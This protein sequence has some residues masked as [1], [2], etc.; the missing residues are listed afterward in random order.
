VPS[1][2]TAS[3]LAAGCQRI[4]HT[5]GFGSTEEPL[6]RTVSGCRER[7]R[8][9]DPAF[10]H[11]TGR[12]HVPFFKGDYYDA[13]RRKNNQVALLLV[14]ALAAAS[15]PAAPASFR[16]LSSPRRGQEARPRRHQVL[17]CLIMFVSFWLRPQ[18]L[19]RACSWASGSSRIRF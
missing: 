6:R 11:A 4:G 7:G 3:P 17:P 15:P 9:S 18:I 10:S 2:L 1:P 13:L 8:P 16:F 12:G 14:E 19:A 5:H